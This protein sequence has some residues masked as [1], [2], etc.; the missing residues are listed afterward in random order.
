MPRSR[1][2]CQFKVQTMLTVLTFSS[3]ETPTLGNSSD[4]SRSDI[5]GIV[6]QNSGRGHLD[7]TFEAERSELR[8][9][10]A[11]STNSSADFAKNTHTMKFARA[12]IGLCAPLLR[13]SAAVTP[14]DVAPTI[15]LSARQQ[16]PIRRP[17]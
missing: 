12:A 9:W 3:V 17:R 8:P 14:R 5:E 1:S 2:C 15:I 7:E 16:L 4:D 10:E 13:N 11:A 6:L